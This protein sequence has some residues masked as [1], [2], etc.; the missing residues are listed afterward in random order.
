MAGF[1]NRIV[2][3]EV[4]T[5]TTIAIMPTGQLRRE[6]V[7]YFP[8]LY[9]PDSVPSTLAHESPL[10]TSRCPYWEALSSPVYAAQEP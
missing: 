1:K 5:M 9:R 8:K 4:A 10:G 3:W 2:T 6:S 7:S